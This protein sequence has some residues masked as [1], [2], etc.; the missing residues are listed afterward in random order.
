MLKLLSNVIILVR[1]VGLTL[2]N[3][4]SKKIQSL[5]VAC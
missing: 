2:V 1:Y 4:V 5:G 3:D